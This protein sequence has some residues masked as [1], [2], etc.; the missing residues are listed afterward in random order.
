MEKVSPSAKNLLVVQAK[1]I[2]KNG[3]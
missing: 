2:E 3:K 1:A